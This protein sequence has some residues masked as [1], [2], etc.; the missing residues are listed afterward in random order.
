MKSEYFFLLHT[1]THAGPG[2]SRNLPTLLEQNSFKT[3]LVLVDQGVADNSLY[4][5]E[6]MGIIETAGVTVHQE[7]LRGS[8]EPDYDYLDQVAYGV[9]KLSGVDAV[10]GIGGGS[11]L[12]ITK[13]VAVLMTNPGKGIEYR[14]FDKVQNP[15]L[16]VIAI[17]TTAGTGSEVTINAVFTDKKEMK[18]LGINGRYM[19]AAYAVLDAL[20]TL[21]CPHQVA[22]SSGMDA[23]VH[24]LESFMCRQAN[25]LT[26]V[27]SSAAFQKI[28]TAL[29]TLTEDPE[30][31][32]KRQQ[33]LLGAY[34]AGA[35]LF[36]SG[37]GISGALSYPLGVH[38][39]VPHGVG[40]GMFIGSVLEYNVDHGFYDYALLWDLVGDDKSGTDE[41][42]SRR[43]V[44]LVKKVAEQ[45]GVPAHLNQW[46]VTRENLHEL[47]QHVVPLQAAFDQ[48]PVPFSAETDALAMLE[49]HIK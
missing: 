29:P 32:D 35:A 21:S 9:R 8:E 5:K 4:F 23:L 28:I 27:Y 25:D 18:K 7:T 31:E 48:N 22:V 30:N 46:G 24:S 42:K 34:L 41:E 3:C 36:N 11:C 39:K 26:R 17:P 43:V 33:I 20:W 19:N 38:H 47:H 12:D 44:D 37:S 10:I 49:K 6:V 40:G 1:R 2:C 14:G 16:P 15:G 13:A 45:I